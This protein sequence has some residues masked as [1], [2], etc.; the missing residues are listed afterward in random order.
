MNVDRHSSARKY[1]LTPSTAKK[2]DMLSLGRQ[3]TLYVDDHDNY[4]CLQN[5]TCF[6]LSFDT[7]ADYIAAWANVPCHSQ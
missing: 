4:H 1:R 6:P 5:T 2:E 3:T 7:V